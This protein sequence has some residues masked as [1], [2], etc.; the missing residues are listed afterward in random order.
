[1]MPDT[2][3]VIEAHKKYVQELVNYLDSS[4]GEDRTEVMNRLKKDLE[5]SYSDM[6]SD[7]TVL[8]SEVVYELISMDIQILRSFV[9]AA[10]SAIL[11]FLS[12]ISVGFI[13]DV[14]AIGK[15]SETNEQ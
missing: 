10:K 11:E 9:S 6:S 7:D 5:K 13:I 14:P 1:M 12:G 2:V 4:E 8:T 15:E 3:K